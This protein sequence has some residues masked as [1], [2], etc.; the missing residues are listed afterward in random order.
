MLII[1]KIK[2]KYTISLREKRENK[3]VAKKK[4]EK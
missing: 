3:K 2:I 1:R 4:E